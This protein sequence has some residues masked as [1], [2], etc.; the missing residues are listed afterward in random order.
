[1]AHGWLYLPLRGELIDEQ[2]ANLFAFNLGYVTFLDDVVYVAADLLRLDQ[3]FGAQL[4]RSGRTTWLPVNHW[5]RVM[6][7]VLTF[8]PRAV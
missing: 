3:L 8:F 1:M 6:N 4:G 7:E 2:L 5:D